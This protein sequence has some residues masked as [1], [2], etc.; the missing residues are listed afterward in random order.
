MRPPASTY[1]LGLA[2]NWEFDKE[3][4]DSIGEA[5]RAGGITIREIH[6][7]DLEHTLEQLKGNQLYFHVV[8]DRASDEEEAF[9]PLA[10]ELERHARVGELRLV[11]PYELMKKAADKATMHLE[12]LAHG[13]QVPYTIIISPYN[14]K[15]E[16]GFTLT[17]L[18]KLGRPFIIKPANTTGIP[19]VRSSPDFEERV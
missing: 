18:A 4:V 17:D 13:V 1:D 9:H 11:N 2:W 19:S 3:F 6:R 14:Q 10:G 12:L 16:I 7:A 5:A 15:Q 8:L